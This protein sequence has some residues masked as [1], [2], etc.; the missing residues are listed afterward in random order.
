MASRSSPDVRRASLLLS[1]LVLTGDDALEAFRDRRVGDSALDTAHLKRAREVL[2]AVHEAITSGDDAR[3]K[4]LEQAW[5]LL[6]EP[7]PEEPKQEPEPESEPEAAAPAAASS[8]AVS[9][10]P[11]AAAAAVPE[12]PE[13]P[14]SSPKPPMAAPAPSPAAAPSPAVPAA[15]G[16][17][18]WARDGAPPAAASPPP[19]PVAAPPPSQPRPAPAPPAPAPAAA[20]M[21]SAVPAPVAPPAP[22]PAPVAPPA[23]A[24]AVVVPPGIDPSR[25]GNVKVQ[26]SDTTQ[27][28]DDGASSDRTVLP[29]AGTA[30]PPPSAVGDVNAAIDALGQTRMGDEGAPKAVTLPFK[31]PPGVKPPAA[32][33]PP[34]PSH[35][36]GLNLEHYAALCAERDVYKGW[37]SQ[38]EARYGI[39]GE[40]DKK[41]VDAHFRAQL[42]ADPSQMAG[43]RTHYARVEAWAREQ[44]GD[45]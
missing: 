14:A 18:P 11:P 28:G 32:G 31:M 10:P 43:W 5:Q 39:T 23:A 25:V 12:P 36:S 16:S 26:L 29:F 33:A 7:S 44:R 13:A 21:A 38:V 30:K 22:A 4:R 3:L 34:L 9:P 35:L 42:K 24:P 17:S 20:P 1:G 40:D 19:S 8:E 2:D 45:G 37:E 15:A 6:C 41:A 27:P